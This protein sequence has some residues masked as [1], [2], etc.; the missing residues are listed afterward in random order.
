MRR[1]PPCGSR[2]LLRMARIGRL[3]GDR[4]HRGTSRTYSKKLVVR[5][6]YSWLPAACDSQPIRRQ[7]AQGTVP[8][9]TRT[10]PLH[11][12]NVA[13]KGAPL[14]LAVVVRPCQLDEHVHHVFGLAVPA[15]AALSIAVMRDQHCLAPL[16]QREQPV[17]R[18][19]PGGGVFLGFGIEQAGA[20]IK[21]DEVGRQS[22]KG[23]TA[24]CPVGGVEPWQVLLLPIGGHDGERGGGTARRAA[25]H[26][27]AAKANLNLKARHLPIDCTPRGRGSGA[28][29]PNASTPAA[30]TNAS[31]CR[32]QDLPKPRSQGIDLPD[33]AFTEDRGVVTNQQRLARGEDVRRQRLE[34]QAG[35][36]TPLGVQR[37]L[38]FE[39]GAAVASPCR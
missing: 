30:A 15:G 26:R 10:C 4:R 22:T 19:L 17:L 28:R 35:Q 33:V 12:S 21:D 1:A 27:A 31:V 14:V 2:P 37:R 5:W 7:V 8:R 6:S 39:R 20:V 13:M 9:R 24:A 23:S 16:P 29:K 18:W 38:G 3:S 34:R 25:G 32:N 36:R 11:L